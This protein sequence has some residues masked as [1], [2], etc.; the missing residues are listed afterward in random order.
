[1][2]VSQDSDRNVIFQTIREDRAMWIETDLGG[3]YN[4]GGS[5]LETGKRT[6]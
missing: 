4:C 5:C 2:T 1:M 6:R 3:T